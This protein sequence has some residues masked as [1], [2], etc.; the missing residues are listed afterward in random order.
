MASESSRC[1]ECGA[2]CERDFC[3]PQ[4][5]ELWTHGPSKP[6]GWS[7]LEVG[8]NHIIAKGQS[9]AKHVGPL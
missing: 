9:K 4:C 3:S 7:L 5:E 6:P 1:E 8:I 2:S